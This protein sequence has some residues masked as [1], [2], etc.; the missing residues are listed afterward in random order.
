MTLRT[1]AEILLGAVA[2]AEAV[3]LWIL[4]RRCRAL[5]RYVDHHTGARETILRY[6]RKRAS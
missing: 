1:F 3:A 4:A 6:S 2:V 5:S